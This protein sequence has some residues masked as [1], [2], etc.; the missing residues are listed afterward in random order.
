MR[1]F[2]TCFL[3]AILSSYVIATAKQLVGDPL[4]CAEVASKIISVLLLI[5]TN[6]VLADELPL[7]LLSSPSL[8]RALTTLI[9]VAGHGLRKSFLCMK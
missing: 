1:D 3:T 7:A 2:L 8:C 4:T 5:L 6:R 9:R